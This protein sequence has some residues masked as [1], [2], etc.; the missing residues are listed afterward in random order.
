MHIVK[1]N[2]TGSTNSYLREYSRI[3]NTD[4][5]VLVWT[6]EQYAGRGQMGTKWESE[7]GKNLLFSVYRRVRVLP[8]NQQFY[9][10]MATSLA[11]FDLLQDLGIEGVQ[12]KWPNDIL[13][14]RFKVC[15]ILIESVIKSGRLSAVIIGV[16]LNVNQESFRIAKKASSL[17]MLTGKDFDLEDLLK[18]LIDLFYTYVTLITSGKFDELKAKYEANLFRRGLVSAFAI[19]GDKKCSGIIEGVSDTGMLRVRFE[20]EPVKEFGLKEIELLY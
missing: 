11:I 13:A 12:V 15:G 1:L 2:A 6:N 18:K 5:D 3:L 19:N 4:E 8:V 9:I 16:G 14:G 10:T 7:P 20:D 17:K